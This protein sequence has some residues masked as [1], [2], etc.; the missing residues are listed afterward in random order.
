VKGRKSRCFVIVV[1]G[2]RCVN[3][4]GDGNGDGIIFCVVVVYSGH[5]IYKKGNTWFSVI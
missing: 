2:A 1:V 3:V 4:W 5:A